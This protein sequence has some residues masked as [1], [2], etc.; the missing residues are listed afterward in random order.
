MEFRPGSLKK[1]DM[2]IASILIVV[3]QL[4]STFQTSKGISDDIR[5]LRAEIASVRKDHEKYF[6]KKEELGTV[7]VTLNRMTKELVRINQQIKTLRDTAYIDIDLDDMAT[8]CF[9]EQLPGE[10]KL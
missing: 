7:V 4:A 6:V 9:Q 5:D 1:R 2:G 8:S 10:I 3:S